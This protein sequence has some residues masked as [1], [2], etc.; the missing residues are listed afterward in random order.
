MSPSATVGVVETS[1]FASRPVEPQ[2]F[3]DPSGRRAV[4]L[5]RVVRAVALAFATWMAA[6]MLG[7]T[8]FGGLPA[9][10]PLVHH[11]IHASRPDIDRLVRAHIRVGAR[12]PRES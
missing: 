4:A 11:A 12:R 3:V 10:V 2:V 9:P 1:S 6:L 7:A 5:R 8:G